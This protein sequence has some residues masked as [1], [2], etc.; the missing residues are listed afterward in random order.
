MQL[1]NKFIVKVGNDK[2]L[3]FLLGGLI[4]ACLTIM[5]I[6]SEQMINPSMMVFPLIGVVFVWIISIFKEAVLDGEFSWAD[7]FAGTIG[8]STVF[9][10]TLIGYLL[11]IL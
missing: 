1:V 5:A 4:S 7:I 11:H 9:I 8:A 3:H 6:L 10:P 2:V